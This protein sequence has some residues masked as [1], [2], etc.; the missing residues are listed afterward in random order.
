MPVHSR[1]TVASS[2]PVRVIKTLKF[3]T[4][5]QAVA[6]FGDQATGKE[7]DDRVRPVA[8]AGMPL[9]AVATSSSPVTAAVMREVLYSVSRSIERAMA[10]VA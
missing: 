7:Y 3:R 2:S 8:H 9:P 1:V 10:S 5:A 4:V 6:S